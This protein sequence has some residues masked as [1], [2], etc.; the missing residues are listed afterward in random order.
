MN[1][2]ETHVDCEVTIRVVMQ[3]DAIENRWHYYARNPQAALDKHPGAE[4]TVDQWT[5]IGLPIQ[6]PD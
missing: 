6:N 4:L 1:D 3:F 5:K 2:L